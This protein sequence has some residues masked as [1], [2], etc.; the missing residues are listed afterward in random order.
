MSLLI[1][2]SLSCF[3]SKDLE[4][5]AAPGLNHF[6]I[7]FVPFYS[8]AAYGADLRSPV[9]VTGVCAHGSRWNWLVESSINTLRKQF[10]L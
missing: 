2:P 4:F 8:S 9:G 5:T 7:F 10:P 3:S 1:F 6:G